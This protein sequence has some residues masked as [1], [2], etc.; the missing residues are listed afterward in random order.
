MK[1]K[2]KVVFDTNV[3]ISALLFGGNPRQ[4]LELARAL[5]IELVCSKAIYLELAEKLQS[6]FFWEVGAIKELIIGLSKFS[7]IVLP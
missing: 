7:T 3:Y 6:K 4:C 5:E 2:L 1:P